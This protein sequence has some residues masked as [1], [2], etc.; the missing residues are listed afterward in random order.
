MA[1]RTKAAAKTKTAQTNATL[2][3]YATPSDALGKA[4]QRKIQNTTVGIIGLGGV[5]GFAALLCSQAGFDIIAA[6]G[7]AVEEKNLC[8]QALYLPNDIGKSK[9]VVAAGRLTA[10]APASKIIAIVGKID[11]KNIASYFCG[12]DIIL[13]CTDNFQTR[14]VIE[15]FCA[16]AGKPWIYASATNFEAMAALVVGGKKLL[17]K[18]EPE[19]K[20]PATLNCTCATAAAIQMRLLY[21]WMQD[22]RLA[23]KLYYF[24]LKTMQ[25]ASRKL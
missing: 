17:P 1:I 23:G 11:E 4:T 6:D 10:H 13:D 8:R 16:K 24:D 5:G 18:T 9:A 22:S 15:S 20:P 21:D 2:A 3:R 19:Q 12:C 25:L 7:D 14:K